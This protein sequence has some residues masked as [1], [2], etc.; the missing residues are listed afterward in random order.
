MLLEMVLVATVGGGSLWGPPRMIAAMVMDEGVLPPPATFE[1]GP[2][3]AAM[4]IHLM[5]SIILGIVLG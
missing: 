5:L 1:I 3:M 2:M 4:A